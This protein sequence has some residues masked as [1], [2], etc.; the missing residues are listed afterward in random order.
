MPHATVKF[1][2]TSTTACEDLATSLALRLVPDFILAS[3]CAGNINVERRTPG[4][5]CG[6]IAYTFS[7][8]YMMYFHAVKRFKIDD[9]SSD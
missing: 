9:G 2:W 1:P 3:W 4:N 6:N 7:S 8:M 5:N